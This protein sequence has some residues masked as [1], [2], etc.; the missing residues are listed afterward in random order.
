MNLLSILY[1]ASWT[2]NDPF[3]LIVAAVSIQFYTENR[4][5]R[6]FKPEF[7][8]EARTASAAAVTPV[9]SKT[10]TDKDP[11]GPS[12]NSVLKEI[13]SRESL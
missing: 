5:E 11:W 1:L 6:E 4:K 2:A 8:I 12:S 13:D 9:S 10:Q 7:F 3:G